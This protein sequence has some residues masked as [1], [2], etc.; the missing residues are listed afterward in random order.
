MSDRLSL[1]Q[2]RMEVTALYS[3]VR[4]IS[5]SDPASAS[6]FFRAQRDALFENHTQS[7]L[8]PSQQK[9]FQG[10]I[11]FDY[12]DRFRIIGTIDQNIQAETRELHLGPDGLMRYTRIARI[13][14]ILLERSCSLDLFWIE[15][16]GGG[17]FLP[18]R[19]L[20]SGTSTYSAGR[21][22]FDT[23]KGVN[24]GT[25]SSSINLDFNFAYNPSCAYNDSWVCP[26]LPNENR[27]PVL[28]NAGEKAYPH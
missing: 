17:I 23:I 7:P 2:W 18:F 9:V 16:Y 25:D 28:V 5:Q 21:Y 27:L 22:L 12:D 6:N 20:T 19:D 11:Y 3:S 15:G 13:D 26:L 14:F 10:L 4:D 8:S 24:L 1:A